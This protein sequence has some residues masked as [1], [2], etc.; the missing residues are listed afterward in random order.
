[1][2][3]QWSRL[4][5]EYDVSVTYRMI[6]LLPSWDRFHDSTHSLSRPLQMGPEWMYAG[7]VCGRPVADTIWIT[8]PPASSFPACIAV[9]CAELQSGAMGALYLHLLREAVLVRGENIAETAVLLAVATNLARSERGFDEKRFEDEI[10]GTKARELFRRDY[11]EAQYLGIRRT[12]TLVFKHNGKRLALH[13]YQ[14][15]AELRAT[16]EGL[17]K[18]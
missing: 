13:G 14:P 10:T 12:P 8:D 6:G 4:Q 5:Q 9:K 15:G 16:M 11:Q 3:P 2:E 18:G 1:M 17:L 7:Q